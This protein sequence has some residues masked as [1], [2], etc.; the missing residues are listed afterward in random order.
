MTPR[1]RQP[2]LAEPSP[3]LRQF[4]RFAQRQAWLIVLVPVIAIAAAAFTVQRQASVYRASMGIVVA[5][6]SVRY[7]PPLGNQALA[8]TMKGILKSDV[9]ARR[10]DAQLALPISSAELAKKLRVEFQPD[11]SVL[12]VSYDS[13]DKD[14]ALSVVTEVGAAF[15]RVA[16]D[17]GVS[18][19][20]NRPGP[21]GIVASIFDPPHL[22]AGRVS[23]RPKQVLGFAGILGLALGL[24]LAF[25]RESL[26]D[27]IRSRDDAEEAFG[28]PVIG[29][30][31][32]RFRARPSTMGHA[33]PS[34]EAEDALQTL[35]ANFEAAA[36]GTTST[37]LI[38]SAL[39]RDKPANVVANL[40][41]ALALEGHDVLCI[42]ADVR[43]PILNRLLG[44]SESARGLLSV[45]EDGAPPERALEE[46]ELV[47]ASKN[48][49]AG[50]A[51][52]RPG[53]R[54]LLMP[55][56]SGASDVSAVV[57][58]QR[59]LEVVAQLSA[60]SRYVLI[61][62]PG[63]LSTPN[64]AASIASHVDSVLVVAR[65][66]RTRREWAEKVRL[67]LKAL[68]TRK[69]ALV[70]TDVKWPLST[71]GTE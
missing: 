7:Q 55:A 44:I 47:A 61:H 58:S 3:P 11:S 13:T 24:I 59:L 1:L 6:S 15:K 46:I 64:G 68:G 51:R 10:V 29:A 14:V 71:V 2:P 39:D 25:A 48:G 56:G 45:V 9:V 23:P 41:V 31:P 12:N 22:Q 30:L 5:Q 63:L 53:G 17:V 69:V 49:P 21:L 57:S 36:N 4:L 20:L 19:R 28:A 38:T 52:E 35:R 43:R 34:K 40:A 33:Q 60:G 54:L 67:T 37:F 66:G 18:T 8:Q 62:S 16:R 32:R 70:L 26:D 42:D 27:R 65:Q 50:A